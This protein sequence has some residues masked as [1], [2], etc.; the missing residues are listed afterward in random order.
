MIKLAKRMYR[1]IKNVPYFIDYS[2]FKTGLR[3]LNENKYINRQKGKIFLI[4]LDCVRADSVR[5]DLMPNLKRIANEGLMCS[6]CYA[7]APF[8]TASIVSILTGLNPYRHGVRHLVGEK[9]EHKTIVDYLQTSSLGLVSCFHLTHLGL[10]ERFSD[11]IF[12]LNLI[13]ANDGRGSYAPSERIVKLALDNWHKYSFFFL[14]LFDAHFHS[15]ESYEEKYFLSI[16]EMDKNLKKI[17]ERVTRDDLLIITADHGK[18]WTGE[19][20]FPY[21]NYKGKRILEGVGHG[22]ELYNEVLRVPLVFWGRNVESMQID[23]VI[24]S[25]D[26]LPTVC[27]L[28][29]ISLMENLDG[30][31][32]LTKTD[33]LRAY[34]ETFTKETLHP[35]KENPPFVCLQDKRWKII[36]EVLDRKLKKYQVFDLK[37][38]PKEL[39]PFGLQEHF[40]E[41]DVLEEWLFREKKILGKE[42]EEDIS[43]Y[44]GVIKERLR[45]LG[46]M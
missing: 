36:C 25:V 38:D 45:D 34:S 42:K 40:P 22:P 23:E 32:I 8:T 26:I 16:K 44:S 10:Q 30:V 1:S 15:S 46:Y 11:Y 7:Q 27:G 39:N 6:N 19:H 12:P 24:R 20:D 14:H 43:E 5:E 33:H 13:A 2:C 41:V 4:I 18:K 35:D 37:N 9:V 28:L 31:N 29:N 17:F 3:H 21:M